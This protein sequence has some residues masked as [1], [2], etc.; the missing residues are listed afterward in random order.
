MSWGRISLS[1]GAAALGG[2][3]SIGAA[4]DVDRMAGVGEVT[5]ASRAATISAATVAVEIAGLR[6]ADGVVRVA[7]FDQPEDF[8]RGRELTGQNVPA[9]EGSVTAVFPGLPPGRYA[10]AF[11]HDEDGNGEFDTNFIG[12][13]MEGYGFS[14]DAPVVFGPPKFDDAAVEVSGRLA[15]TTAK[16][17]Y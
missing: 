3:L 7:I 13:P 12:L 1:L 15:R 16:V 14:N 2:L 11:Y 10:I 17:R 8:P 5:V 4:A 9:A 6:S